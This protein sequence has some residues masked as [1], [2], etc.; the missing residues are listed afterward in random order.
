[1]NSHAL[2]FNQ[3]SGLFLSNTNVLLLHLWSPVPVDEKL[4]FDFV[5]YSVWSQNEMYIW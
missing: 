5:F 1:M 3:T 2:I 4:S